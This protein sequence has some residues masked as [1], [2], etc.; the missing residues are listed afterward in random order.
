MNY[1]PNLCGNYFSYPYFLVFLVILPNLMVNL[2]TAF[3]VEG[4]MDSL[5]EYD[6]VINKFQ[7]GKKIFIK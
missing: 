3:L 7:M 2:F 4:Y 6:A 1:G 5:K